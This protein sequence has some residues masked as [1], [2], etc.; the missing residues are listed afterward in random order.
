MAQKA[1]RN[2]SHPTTF[3]MAGVGAVRLFWLMVIFCMSIKLKRAISGVHRALIRNRLKIGLGW[4]SLA[5]GR[6]EQKPSSAE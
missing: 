3:Q 6:Q 2:I 1:L 4:G 5:R